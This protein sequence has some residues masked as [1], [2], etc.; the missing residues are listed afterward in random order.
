M[1]T[2]FIT[3]LG[4]HIKMPNAGPSRFVKKSSSNGTK[5]VMVRIVRPGVLIG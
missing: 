1:T 5:I 4:A 2:A 3:R